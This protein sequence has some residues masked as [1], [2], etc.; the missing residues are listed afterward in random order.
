[1]QMKFLSAALAVT[2]A[3]TAAHAHSPYLLPNTFDATDRD[4]ITVQA[5]FA[6]H[7]FAPDVVMKADDYHAIGPDGGRLTV[8]P[9]YLQD[10][11]VFETATKANGTYR[12]TT[13][14]RAGR[15]SKA[16]LNKGEWEFLDPEK[17]VPA[18]VNAVDMQSITRAEVYV[19]RGAPTDAALAAIGK[20]IEFRAL[21]HPN[22]IFVGQPAVFET[23]LDGKPLP[24]QTIELHR[25][26][27]VY[28]DGD[29]GETL[30]TD[31]AGRFTVKAAAPGLYHA[32]TRYR[33][34]AAPGAPAQSLTYALTFEATK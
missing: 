25:A 30:V 32:M 8:T 5:A 33:R 9:T 13:G 11:A 18:G 6:E 4:H 29:K 1:M 17:P 27:E 16:F 22:S 15:I 31:A 26:D 34:D 2:M 28:A 10:V 20:G 21:T 19:S 14:T 12:I 7:F 23:L 3:A 24:N